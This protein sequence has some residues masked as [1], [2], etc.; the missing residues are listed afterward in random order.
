MENILKV[1]IAGIAF[2]CWPLLMNK[3]ALSPNTATFMSVV[4]PAFI[5]G[6]IVLYKGLTIP[7]GN[8]WWFGVAA[9]VVTSIGLII[10]NSTIVQVAPQDAG[11]LFLIMLM[12]QISVPAVYH[13]VVNHGLSWRVAVGLLA[14]GAACILLAQ[15]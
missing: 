3:S 10:F 14:A 15:K 5:V 1:V 4:L 6:P 2:G 9:A 11:R 7:E 12:A 8:L 13:V